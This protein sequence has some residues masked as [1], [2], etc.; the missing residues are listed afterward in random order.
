[1]IATNL[2][3]KHMSQ[4]EKKNWLIKKWFPLTIDWMES[5]LEYESR[6]NSP[7]NIKICCYCDFFSKGEKKILEEVC[8]FITGN[9]TQIK[10]PQKSEEVRFRK[11]DPSEWREEFSV[12][13]KLWMWEQIP[14][15]MKMRFGWKE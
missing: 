7:F 5:W 8:E 1:M 11:G 12:E 6:N 9:K 14:N 15:A 10:V 13:Q 4:E 2:Q 3:Y